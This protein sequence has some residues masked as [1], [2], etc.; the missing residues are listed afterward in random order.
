MDLYHDKDISKHIE[1]RHLKDHIKM[2]VELYFE[3][4][5]LK[6]YSGIPRILL[7]LRI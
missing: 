7:F 4:K 6:N 2:F 3:R 1:G 5:E